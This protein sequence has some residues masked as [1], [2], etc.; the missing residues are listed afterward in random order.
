MQEKDEPVP[1]LSN[2][3]KNF[4]QNSSLSKE[5]IEKVGIVVE[6]FSAKWNSSYEE[7]TLNDVNFT[8]GSGELV[9]IIGS[10]GSGKVRTLIQIIF[11]CHL[12]PNDFFTI[13]IV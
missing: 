9:T 4:N 6:G 1:D 5:S 8:V 13:Y 10:V 12:F 3:D 7:N 2:K 11:T